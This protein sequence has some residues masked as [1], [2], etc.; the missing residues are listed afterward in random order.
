MYFNVYNVSRFYI[1]FFL[2]NKRIIKQTTDNLL[3][4]PLHALLISVTEVR[5]Q[6]NVRHFTRKVINV[7][8]RACAC[9]YV[10]LLNYTI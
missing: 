2:L 4:S 8:A 9:A 5:S 10:C 1:H 3:Q 7:C 6:L